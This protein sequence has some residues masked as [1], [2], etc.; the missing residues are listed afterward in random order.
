MEQTTL[1]SFEY[2]NR[3]DDA[4]DSITM[5]ADKII[6]ENGLP[7]KAEAFVRPF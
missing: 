5:F 7:M 1:Y 6:E 3:H 2:P 4:I